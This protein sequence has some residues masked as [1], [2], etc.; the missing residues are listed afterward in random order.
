M[1]ENKD[2][3]VE[4]LVLA[5]CAKT[6]RRVHRSDFE[7]QHRC[8]Q[9][10]IPALG[11]VGVF[12]SGAFG[13][14]KR[15]CPSVGAVFVAVF[16]DA[17]GVPNVGA[18]GWFELFPNPENKDCVF[19]AF[20]AAPV[21]DAEFPNKPPPAAGAVEVFAFPKRFDVPEFPN[22]PV[23]VAGFAAQSPSAPASA[24]MGLSGIHTCAKEIS[25][26]RGA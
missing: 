7:Q 13:R 4:L 24:T 20:E 21:F 2:I 9:L 11:A 17:A 1:I 12:D 15:P 5:G 18:D 6:T 14:L 26:T 23:P 22:S 16:D 8:S 25:S 10:G 19:D 3:P